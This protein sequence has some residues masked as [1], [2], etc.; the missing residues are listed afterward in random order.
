[1]H[2]FR[3]QL[4]TW[5]QLTGL[6][7]D[8]GRFYDVADPIVRDGRQHQTAR[9]IAVGTAIQRCPPFVGAWTSGWLGF[10]LRIDDHVEC[11]RLQNPVGRAPCVVTPTFIVQHRDLFRWTLPIPNTDL[12]RVRLGITR[13]DERPNRWRL[14][15]I[16]RLTFP[17]DDIVSAAVDRSPWLDMHRL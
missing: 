11:K 10:G 7:V 6:V 1:L 14:R 9:R 15:D 4:R 12:N 17:H 2:D 16:H 5:Q 3:Q 8:V 13:L